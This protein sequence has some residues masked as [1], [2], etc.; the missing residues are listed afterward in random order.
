MFH[1]TGFYL[2][3]WLV[4]L[5]NL[6]VGRCMWTPRPE[7]ISNRDVGPKNDTVWKMKGGPYLEDY[8]PLNTVGEYPYL[9]QIWSED[10]DDTKQVRIG[11]L[12]SHYAV[13]TACRGVHAIPLYQLKVIA[14]RQFKQEKVLFLPITVINSDVSRRGSNIHL[15]R[16]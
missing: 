16:Q 12:L 10:P 5:L 4:A 1:I 11:S 13:L 6:D 2:A 7:H 8:C 9:V 15:A 3:C 14:Q